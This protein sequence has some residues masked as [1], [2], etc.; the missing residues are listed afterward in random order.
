LLV[1]PA[2]ICLALIAPLGTAD[3]TVLTLGSRHCLNFFLFIS[4]FHS[5][6][7]GPGGIYLSGQSSNPANRRP[8]RIDPSVRVGRCFSEFRT[9]CVG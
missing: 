5:V 7:D 1:R 8:L 6:E 9:R 4:S 3:A 2:G